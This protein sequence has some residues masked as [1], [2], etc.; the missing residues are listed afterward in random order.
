M[1]G[2]LSPSLTLYST[3]IQYLAGFLIHPFTPHYPT[4]HYFTCILFPSYDQHPTAIQ[5]LHPMPQ[6]YQVSFLPPSLIPKCHTI[7]TVV[8]SPY[9]IAYTYL[10]YTWQASFLSPLSNTHI[11]YKT[12]P[13]SLNP[14]TTNT[15]LLYYTWQASLLPPPH[16]T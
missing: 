5:I 10:Y 7:Q 2:I 14:P 3:F 8:H 11:V 13:A 4:I 1:T 16:H 9:K 15:S 6:C 12:L